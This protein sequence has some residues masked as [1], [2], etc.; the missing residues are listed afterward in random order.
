MECFV[1]AHWLP[2]ICWYQTPE[3]LYSW[4]VSRR[5]QMGFDFLGSPKAETFL[6][7][8]QYF[9]L[10][11][12]K[13][14]KERWRILSWVTEQ[15]SLGSV[16][17]WAGPVSLLEVLQGCWS[18]GVLATASLLIELHQALKIP[19]CLEAPD[20]FWVLVQA[21]LM[22]TWEGLKTAFQ[23]TVYGWQSQ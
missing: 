15:G 11:R 9:H 21:F 2:K 7:L 18:K 12:V 20:T 22:G 19:M 14:I 3:C 1:F 8:K 6:F 5:T 17:P 10:L 23:G 16:K 13:G 4:T